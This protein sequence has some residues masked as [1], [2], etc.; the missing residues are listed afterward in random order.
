M[1]LSSNP[2]LTLLESEQVLLC[3]AEKKC[4]LLLFSSSHYSVSFSPKCFLPRLVRKIWSSIST[5][6]DQ[7]PGRLIWTSTHLILMEPQNTSLLKPGAKGCATNVRQIIS[8]HRNNMVKF[9][10]TTI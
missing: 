8:P 9:S 6:T 5:P 10:R 2:H 1:G 7:L 4:N 3:F